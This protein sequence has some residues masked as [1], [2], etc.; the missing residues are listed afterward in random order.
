MK[1]TNSQVIAAIFGV[2]LC[3]GTAWINFSALYEAY[4]SGPPYFSRTTNMDK[5]KDPLPYLIAADLLV[6]VVASFAFRYWLKTTPISRNSGG[7]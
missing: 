1:K 5:W 6:L 2:A 4:G 7:A 3:L